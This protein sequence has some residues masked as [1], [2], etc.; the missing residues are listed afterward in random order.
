MENKSS[1]VEVETYKKAITE[2]VE[3]IEN[4]KLLKRIYDYIYRNIKRA[5]N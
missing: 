3:S 1:N 4:I 5:G 2:L